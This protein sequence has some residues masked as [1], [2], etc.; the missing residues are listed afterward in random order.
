MSWEAN[1]KIF[2]QV[3][4]I[5]EHVSNS[6]SKSKLAKIRHGPKYGIKNYPWSNEKHSHK[7]NAENW[8]LA[9]PWTLKSA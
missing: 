7:R 2:K 5:S 4:P 8:G 6:C 3:R 1:I 9:A